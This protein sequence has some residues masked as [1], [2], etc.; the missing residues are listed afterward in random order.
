MGTTG[1]ERVW[2][3]RVNHFAPARNLKFETEIAPES[4]ETQMFNIAD[5]SE[6][7]CTDKWTF[8]EFEQFEQQQSENDFHNRCAIRKH[9]LPHVLP[10]SGSER[11]WKT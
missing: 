1:V 7:V 3:N 2:I 4:A 11:L 8:D 6:S 9:F 5:D 10:P